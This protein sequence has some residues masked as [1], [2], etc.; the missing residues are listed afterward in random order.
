MAA[1][2]ATR[3]VRHSHAARRMCLSRSF[4]RARLFRGSLRDG[5]GGFYVRTYKKRLHPS[6]SKEDF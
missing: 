1:V 3:Y 6:L 4:A 5:G 2:V